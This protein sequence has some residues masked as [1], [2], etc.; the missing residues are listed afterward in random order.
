MAT[1]GPVQIQGCA[2]RI[3][4]LN[5][6]GSPGSGASAMFQDDRSFCKLEYKPVMHEGKEFTPE[7]ACGVP[8][9]SYKDYNRFKRWEIVLTMGAFDPEMLNLVGQGSLYT[10]SGSS[11]RTVTDGITVN[12]S[13]EITSATAAF[14][15]TDVGRT[16]TGTGIPSSPPTYITEI[17]DGTH[18]R[19]SQVATASASS[20]SLTFGS[21]P[22]GTIGYAFPHLL[23]IPAPNGISIEIWSKLIVRGTGYQGATPY[24][25]AGTATIPG[26]AYARIGFFRCYLWHDANTVEDKEQ[27]PMFTGWAIE[28]ANF[29]TGPNDDWRT[30]AL[31]ATGTPVDTTVPIGVLC[32]PS[33][34]TPLQPGFQSPLI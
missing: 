22:V 27:S 21:Q 5:A 25:S 11:G 16:V 8:V 6:D 4:A 2:I 31:P 28:N 3:A 9:I 7:S 29:G 20:V 1:N 32:D 33:L 17:V 14:L 12:Q 23:Y 24:P 30:T 13:N 15:G 18:A 10:S 34:P 19:L 26:S